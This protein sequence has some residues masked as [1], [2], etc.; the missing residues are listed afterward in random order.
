M[1]I[2]YILFLTLKTLL[3]QPKRLLSLTFGPPVRLNNQ[4]RYFSA[5]SARER[6]E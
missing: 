1:R 3:N 5:H 4:Y 6:Y 2:L